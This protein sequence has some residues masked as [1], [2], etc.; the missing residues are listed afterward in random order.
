MNKGVKIILSDERSGKTET[1]HYEGGII[2][3]VRYVDENKDKINEEPIYIEGIK[4]NNIVEVQYSIAILTM[5][6]FLT[7]VNNN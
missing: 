3:F 4:E 2:E 6:I 7:F 5:K 1:F